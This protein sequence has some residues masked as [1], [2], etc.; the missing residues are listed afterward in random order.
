[1]QQSIDLTP[2]FP[3]RRG[4]RREKNGVWCTP[5]LI[6]KHRSEEARRL[7]GV[8]TFQCT[9]GGREHGVSGD[10]ARGCLP[11]SGER[12]FAIRIDSAVASGGCHAQRQA[13]Q[14]KSNS[15]HANGTR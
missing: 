2:T 4:A 15:K 9:L 10:R 11:I 14:R 8:A 13:Q 12:H 7:P 5:C 3:A 1:M 6:A